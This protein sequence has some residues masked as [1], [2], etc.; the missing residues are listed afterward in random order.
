MKNPLDHG[1]VIVDTAKST[2]DLAERAIQAG[3]PEGAI[4]A[5]MQTEGR[6]R[7]QRQWHATPDDSLT[8]SLVFHQ[9]PNHPKPYLLGMAVA[10]AAAGALHCQLKWPNDLI[11]SG[12]KVGGILT[13]VISNPEGQKI[14][15]VGVGINLNQRE[16]PPEIAHR[17]ISL[18]MAHGNVSDPVSTLKA[19]GTHIEL[20]PEPNSWSD[21]EKAWSLFD[22]TPGTT[23]KPPTGEPVR[24]VGIG[25]EGQLI[26]ELNN[27]TVSIY[28]ADAIIGNQPNQ[29]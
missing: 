19:I 23:Y 13:E 22:D 11:I 12:Q 2:Q 9:Y 3:Q 18:F 21:L 17:A 24:A 5:R 4:V 28:A 26:A 14:T 27:E 15:V 20:L 16:F 25:S 29:N 10:I 1:Y 6:G 8:C 7:F